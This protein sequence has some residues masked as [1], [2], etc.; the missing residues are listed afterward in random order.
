MTAGEGPV[1]VRV[2]VHSSLCP[3]LPTGGEGTDHPLPTLPILSAN[4][5][6]NPRPLP[7]LCFAGLF[8]VPL[9]TPL[10][11][12]TLFEEGAQSRRITLRVSPSTMLLEDVLILGAT[13]A[14]EDKV[15]SAT[16][17]N[18]VVICILSPI[19]TLYERDV[20]PT[21]SGCSSSL[22]L[23]R[24]DKLVTHGLTKVGSET[25]RDWDNHEKTGVDTLK[26]RPMMGSKLYSA[27]GPIAG[28][29]A[30]TGS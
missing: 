8:A 29:L 15:V 9:P 23:S 24:S 5:P 20:D 27:G 22:D 7:V 12:N 2:F 4:I 26:G 11:A 14:E 17:G 30:G 28:K 19:T 25:S 13:V 3:D 10:S 16:D 6:T 1:L 21:T 18:T